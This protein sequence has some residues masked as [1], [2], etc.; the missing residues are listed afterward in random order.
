MLTLTINKSGRINKD[1]IEIQNRPRGAEFE[2][3]DFLMRKL[4][5]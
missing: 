4:S 2:L 3:F 5:A 1:S